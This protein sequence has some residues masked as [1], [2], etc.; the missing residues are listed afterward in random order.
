MSAESGEHVCAE[1][2]RNHFRLQD[3]QLGS[4]VFV[5]P[6]TVRVFAETGTQLVFGNPTYQN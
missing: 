4:Q 5:T 6:Q 2:P 1:I 3:I